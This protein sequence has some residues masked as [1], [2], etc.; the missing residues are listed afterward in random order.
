M[1][2]YIKYYIPVFTSM[3]MIVVLLQGE[4]FPTI[5]ALSFSFSMIF[6]DFFFGKDKVI[7]KFSYPKLLDL[8]LYIHLPVLFILVLLVVSIF[9]NNLSTS[10]IGL[11]NAIFN[12][13]FIQIKKSFNMIDKVSLLYQTALF[14]G[15]FAT[16]PAHEL[17]HRKKNHF[18]MFIGN[19]LLAF[20]WDCTFSI[21]HV[22]G[23]HKDVCLEQDPA[24]AKRG[25]N[26]YLFI[27]RAIA[28]EQIS[29]WKIEMSRLKRR[30]FYFLS[31]HNKMITGYMRSLL[32]TIITF[33]IGGFSGALCFLF[34]AFSG[35]I[36]LESINYI[37]H[38]GLVREKGKPVC[39]RHSWNSNHTFSSIYLCNL[40]RHSDHHRASNLKFWE[41]SPSN[42]E[43]PI[44][45]FGYL[46]MLDVLLL[47]PFL[48][49]RIMAK[50]IIDWDLNYANKEERKIANIQNSRSG[51][52]L[53]NS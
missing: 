20:S 27:L 13:D 5:F 1:L 34:L 14:I 28:A 10:Y 33:I 43:A 24:S 21:E 8:S 29:G 51:I 22:Y 32:I 12:I 48:Y 36:L 11:V 47:A 26:V 31:L 17:T 50:K 15:M 39:L 30:G 2:K 45:P 16:V 3:L 42:E 23:H 35:K 49:H 46:F 40:T 25:E 4:Y 37:Q 19:W 7:Q 18:D 9:S 41:L 6:G 44:L 52:K 38:Y 53:L